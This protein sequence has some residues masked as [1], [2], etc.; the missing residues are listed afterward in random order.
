MPEFIPNIKGG[1]FWFAGNSKDT[2]CVS[3][4]LGNYIIHTNINFEK[5]LEKN[6][7]KYYASCNED[8]YL[9]KEQ[10]KV[11]LNNIE[12]C[13]YK[14]IDN[15]IGNKEMIVMNKFN[16]NLDDTYNFLLE[17]QECL[18]IDILFENVRFY[19]FFS[20]HTIISFICNYI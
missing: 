20:V 15:Y 12:K 11:I 6:S 17:V 4:D 5:E 16:N 8:K 2:A 9:W 10:E 3:A 14:H 18:N 1:Y 7:N 19:D 13:L